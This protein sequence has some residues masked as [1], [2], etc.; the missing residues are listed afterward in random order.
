M[1][2][3]IAF[4][5]KSD[6]LGD[7]GPDDRFEE[8]DSESTVAAIVEVLIAQ[9]HRPRPLGSGRRFLEDVLA[10]P[11][12]L[13]FN[14]AEGFGTR[15]REA[16]VPAVCEM[17]SIPVTHS[18]PLTL[19]V[20]LD[21][22]MAKRL[23]AACGVATP[24]FAVVE[25]PAHAEDLPLQ[26]PVIAKPLFEGSSMGI[27]RRSRAVDV[28]ALRF[29]VERLLSDYDEPVLVEEF[30]PGPEFTVGVLG[31]G[32]TARVIA[33]MEIA[34]KVDRPE[35]FVYSLEVKRNWE[36]EVEYH[37]PP[38]HPRKLVHAVEQLALDAH[39]ALGCR[40]VSRIDI[41]IDALGGPRFLEAN[42]LPGLNPST[43]D[44]VILS[45]RSGLPYAELIG[46][47]VA[48]ARARYAI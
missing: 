36:S 33:V 37:V 46:H 20:T 41:R 38:R 3:G 23:V 43:G 40:D 4:D 7:G 11:P 18:D 26:F 27:R 47:I 1:D 6:H 5:L 16:H 19:A 44:I 29:E 45:A 13:V 31:S 17:L 9:G 28:A 12:E 30:C 25:T 48:E 39:R 10:N 32:A 21:K 22:A 42:P 15:S 24:R 14:F 35:Q 34:P 8:F 2:I